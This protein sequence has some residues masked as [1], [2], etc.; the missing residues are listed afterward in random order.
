MSD[1][2]TDT[3]ANRLGAAV[4]LGAVAMTFLAAAILSPVGL[5]GETGLS[6][7]GIALPTLCLFR[8]STGLPCASCGLTRAV[9]LLLHGRLADSL[10][11]HPFGIAAVGLG[12]F[13]VPPRLAAL[14]G[15]R[16][17]W[18]SRWDRC[19]GRAA[20]AAFLLMIVWWVLTVGPLFAAG[21]RQRPHG[22]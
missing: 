18:I 1:T 17:P 12:L 3:A 16:G 6:L 8:L 19:L 9:V 15:R 10:A 11:V 4:V 14:R 20:L 5:H 7:F 22:L 2:H 13:L 21:W